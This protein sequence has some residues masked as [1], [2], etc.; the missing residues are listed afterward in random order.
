MQKGTK[1][2]ALVILAAGIGARY[3]GGVKQ[4]KKVGPAGEIIMDYAIHDALKVGF[5]KIVFI[6]RKDIEE[7]F[8]QVIGTRIEAVCREKGVEVAYAYQEK[9]DLPDG[10]A[11]PQD[12]KKPWGTGH[13]L[14]ACRGLLHGPF[15]VINADD[16]YGKDAYGKLLAYLQ[17]LPEEAAGSYCMA[18][19]RLGRTLSEYGGV[20]RGICQTDEQMKLTAVKETRGIT[21]TNGEATV[22]RDGQL[23]ILDAE[24]CVSMNMW[25]FTPDILTVL[26]ERFSEFLKKNLNQPTSEYLLPEIVDKLL[27]DG[28]ASVQVLPTED[29]WFGI[30]YQE[31]GPIVAAAFHGMVEQGVYQAPLYDLEQMA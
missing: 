28:K 18:G 10:F 4:L 5:N 26:E 17:K 7:D 12:R 2:Y 24:A 11:C 30:T 27:T 20:T 3:G 21:K 25:G 29:R 23:E 8:R 31:D 6:I 9:E 15:V 14:L 19:F 1:E 13:A 22:L 16:Y